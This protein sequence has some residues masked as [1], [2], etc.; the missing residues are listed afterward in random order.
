MHFG[1]GCWIV[2]FGVAWVL[3]GFGRFGLFGVSFRWFLGCLI[4]LSGGLVLYFCL[5]LGFGGRVW[6]WVLC[7]VLACGFVG[8]GFLVMLL[9]V[10]WFSV[11]LCFEFC[12]VF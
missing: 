8:F 12:W 10:L 3:V 4:V 5:C 11:A 7:V 9:G 1:S 2:V 6:P